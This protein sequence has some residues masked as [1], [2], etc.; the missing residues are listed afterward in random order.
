[1]DPAEF[2]GRRKKAAKVAERG[3]IFAGPDPAN[4]SILRKTRRVLLEKFA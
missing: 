3:A 1:M 2:A 4:N